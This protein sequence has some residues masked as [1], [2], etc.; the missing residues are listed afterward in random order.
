[1][2]PKEKAI[3][4]RN[5]MKNNL[6]SDAEYDAKQCALVVVDNVLS[7]LF[8]DEIVSLDNGYERIVDYWENV[9]TELNAL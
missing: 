2:T 3:E 9:K 4:L 8:E 7:V 6:F 1:M 5:K